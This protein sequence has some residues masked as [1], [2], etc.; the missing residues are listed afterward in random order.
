M[1]RS[2]LDEVGRYRIAGW[3]QDE[4]QPDAPLSLLILVNDALVA[5]V[6]ANRHRPDLAAAGIGDGRHGFRFEFPDSLPSG[7]R[8]IVRVCREADGSDLAGSPVVLE[9]VSPSDELA[10]EAL[11]EIDLAA[12]SDDALARGIELT[13]GHLDSAVQLLAERQSGRA[14]RREHRLLVERWRR[15]GASG[16]RPDSGMPARRALIIDDR[17]PQP[18]RDA[19]S[20]VILSHVRSLQRLGFEVSF[21]ASLDFGTADADRGSLERLGIAR[22]GRPFYGSVEEVLRRQEGEFDLIYL[23]RVTNAVKYGELARQHFPKARHI[24]SVADLHHLRIARQAAAE[25]RPELAPLAN[26]LRLMEFTAAALADAVITHSSDEA[27]LLAAQIGAAKVH[28]V[29]W[30]A[31]ARPTIV[32]FGKRR[33]IA[34]IGGYGHPPNLDAARWLISEIMPRVRE[35]DPKIECL[36]V[37]EG[38][39]DGVRQRCGDGLVAVGGVADL[40]EIFNRVR[41]TVAP[42]RFGA[43]VKGKVIDSLAVGLPCVMT[44]VGAEGLE[45]P[46]ALE[47]CVATTAEGIA[48]AIGHLHNDRKANAACRAAGLGYIEEVFSE[49]RL[50]ALMQQ[51]LGPAIRNLAKVVTAVAK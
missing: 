9:P 2:F 16:E 8:H 20:A 45:L 3:A 27:K 47:G 28:T 42:L 29:R 39:P 43:G 33:G 11:A 15:R 36:L 32:P 19:G 40:A 12:L 48:A 37:G 25:D 26:R 18:E 13:A 23:H 46:A 21:A 7:E 31:T 17:L 24:Y 50:D 6:L 14:A 35:R 49:A 22:C 34:F 38:L 44:P 41:L 5:R 10:H 30:S 1:L 51:V 4:A